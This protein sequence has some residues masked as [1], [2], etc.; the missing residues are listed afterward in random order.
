MEG[1]GAYFENLLFVVD[2]KANLITVGQLY[3]DEH[4][5]LFIK[6]TCRILK[7]DVSCVLQVLGLM[8][9]TICLN[10]KSLAICQKLTLQTCGTNAWDT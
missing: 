8:I 3:D 10:Q 9:N 2:L 5:V 7:N 4:M 1:I 6:S